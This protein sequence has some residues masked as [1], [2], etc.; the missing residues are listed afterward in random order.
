MKSF[1]KTTEGKEEITAYTVDDAVLPPLRFGKITRNRVVCQY[2]DDYAV[3]DTETSHDGESAAWVHQWA[4][5]LRDVYIYGRRPSEF[6]RLLEKLRDRY[7]LN[8]F[9]RLIVYFHNSSY[10]LQYLKRFLQQYDPKIKILA[11]DPHSI[12]ICDVF[13]FRLLCSYKLTHLS[14]DK[15]S[16]DYAVRYR[17]ASGAVDYSVIRYQDEELPEDDWY[18]MFSDVASQ[19]DAIAGYL[20][21]QGYERAY[22]APFT[23][24]GFVRTACRHAAEK[25]REWRGKFLE[26]TLSLE[27]FRLCRQA[28][29]GGITIASY[30]YSDRT[31]R[32]E[33]GHVDFTSSYPARQMMDYFP[34]GR[35]MWYG[36]I[37]SREELEEILTDFCGVFLLHLEGV[38]LREGITAPYIPASKC[39]HIERPLKVNGKVISADRLSIAVTEIDY[40]WITRQYKAAEMRVDHLLIFERGPAPEWLK[41]QI[42]LYYE[43]KC[44]LKHADPVLY[45]ASKALLN[46]IYGMS[47]TSPVRDEYRLNPDCIIEEKDG[48]P[49]GQLNKF[50]A[51]R[52]SFLPYQLGIYTTAH[53]RN[54]LMEM[55]EAV[56]YEKFLYCD[57]DSIFYLKDED[58]ERALGKMNA[59]IRERA[60]RAGA[61]VGDQVLGVAT[62]EPAVTAF[63]ALHAKCY[64]MEEEGQLKVTIAGIPK[65]S[66]KWQDGRPVTR[67]NA[68]ELG[69]IDNLKDGF[70]FRHCGG[71][72]SLY[73]EQDIEQRYINGHLT[74]L[75][76]AVI[77]ENIEKEIS[78]TMYAVG[79]DYGLFDFRQEM[80]CDFGE[81]VH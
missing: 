57:T 29:M 64:A 75:A 54:A 23:S 28:F 43:R 66:T 3:A 33:I 63:R 60:V 51:S 68:E 17:K 6:V 12:L 72:R 35:P 2:A 79:A 71:T 7:H 69:E 39:I 10:D 5:K 70:V 80:P 58:T 24:T 13:G 11:T 36:E 45:M 1:V 49:E 47:A 30:R 27:Q 8:S 59:A 52:N 40:K 53:A 32:G 14:L 74:E 78:D 37:E 62:P 19:H 31:I 41:G 34:T 15:L 22:K 26:S 44:T 61:A 9:K 4:F 55:I 65:R 56:G 21:S 25:D 46:G 38:E 50:Y 42:M 16:S 77:I 18:Y 20:K 48:N 67:S 81:S 76:S 73:I